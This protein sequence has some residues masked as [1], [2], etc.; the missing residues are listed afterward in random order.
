LSDAQG[1]APTPITKETPSGW[2]Q[3]ASPTRPREGLKSRA[4]AR[5]LHKGGKAAESHQRLSP[6]DFAASARLKP[7]PP[8]IPLTGL[9]GPEDVELFL[10]AGEIFVA[11]G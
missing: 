9:Q 5:R 3:K 6:F 11:G 8:E 2:P 4:E 10:D 1:E 7:C